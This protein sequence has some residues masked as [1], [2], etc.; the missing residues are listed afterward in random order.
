MA[1]P[2]DWPS[3]ADL[4]AGAVAQ[5]LAEIDRHAATLQDL[6]LEHGGNRFY[7]DRGSLE[8]ITTTLAVVLMGADADP[9]PTPGHV[10]GKWM[11]ADRDQQTGGRV[12]VPM[13][14]GQFKQ[15]ARALYDRNAAIWDA[16]Q[17]HYVVVENMAILGATAVQI[18]QY[19]HTSG[20]P[21]TIPEIPAEAE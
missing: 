5:K 16:K 19:D 17:G 13:S 14:N 15:L 6:P 9:I 3:G 1:A 21:E 7:A 10:A 4:V 2:A 20:W 12:L 11:S 8:T 18:L